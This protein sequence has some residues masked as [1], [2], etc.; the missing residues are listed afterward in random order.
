[1]LRHISF[2]AGI[3]ATA[4]AQSD[5]DQNPSVEIASCQA[6]ECSPPEG[7]ICSTGD[8][9]G[10]PVGI[11]MA[12]QAINSSSSSPLSFTLI[13]GLDENGFTGIGS[14]EYEYSDQQLF[15][16]VDPNADSYPSGCVLMMQYMGQ[17]LPLEPL[18]DDDTR[19]GAA[20]GTTS[21]QGVVNSLCR[22]EIIEIIRDFD[23]SSSNGEIQCGRLVEHVNTELR[24]STDAC[25]GDGGWISNFF[26]VTGGTLPRSNS[27]TASA[28]R[29]GSDECRPV[30]PASNEMYKVAEMRQFFFH[31]PPEDAASFLGRLYGGRTGWTP[32]MTV[33]YGD[34]E[35]GDESPDVSFLC[36]ETFNSEGEKR[37]SPLDSSGNVMFPGSLMLAAAP[38]LAALA[39]VV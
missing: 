38:L 10:P 17:T 25:G 15:V 12:S 20:E 39:G 5:D 13:D 36:M 18:L 2:A 28:E 11:G 30:L 19:P 6:L 7:S 34:G 26:N 23:D 37:E 14:S 21:C 27:S 22:D 32:V 1:M 33:V 29:L 16:G 8:L 24:G 31:D 4:L 3:A 35:E 9:P